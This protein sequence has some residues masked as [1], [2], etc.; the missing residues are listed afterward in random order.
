MKKTLL[1]LSLIVLNIQFAQAKIWRVNNMLGVVADFTTVTAAY[2]AAQNG[3]TIHIEPS[4]ND[5]DGVSCYKR[6]V[7]ISVGS[8]LQQ[9][10][11]SQFSTVSGRMSSLGFYQGSEG[12]KASVHCGSISIGTNDISIVRSYV[13]SALSVS[14]NVSNALVSQCFINGY[15]SSNATSMVFTN[16][17]V[18][19]GFMMD[20]Q[21]ASAVVTN[22]VFNYNYYAYPGYTYN[23]IRLYNSV[24]QNNISVKGAPFFEMYTS[25][26]IYNICPDTTFPAGN[27]NMR[28]V[29]M[30]T[31]FVNPTG[32]A[33]KD[34]QLKAGSPAIGIGYGGVD[35]GAYGGSTP[36]KLAL[37]P[38]IPAITNLSSPAST[39]GNTIQ[40]TFSAKS[41]N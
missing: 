30:T 5:Y 6:L 18:K 21:Q 39:G 12:S 26:A 28:N 1:F 32:T 41:N 36:F 40:V 7:W 22:N 34:F 15:V 14:Y 35:M 19:G 2:N 17:I 37:Q 29:D 9:N 25:A 23:G 8:F 27:A 38:A 3:D 33:D 13:E 4:V 20:T 11:G 10:P 24:F 31:V 16:N